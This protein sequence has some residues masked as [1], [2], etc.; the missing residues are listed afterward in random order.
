M[1]TEA[2]KSNDIFGHP[3]GLFVLFFTE[4]WERF[5]Y[6]GMRALLVLYMVQYLLVDPARSSQVIGYPTLLSILTSVFGELNIQQIS[7]QIYG[8]YT[9]FVYLTPLFGGILADRYLGQHKTV[10][11]G[12]IFFVIG[13]FL[14][15]IESMFIIAMIFLFIGNGC[16]KPNISTQVGNCYADDD[17]R[18]DRAYLIFY[19]GINLGAFF[20]P[21]V[22][23]TLGQ[24]LGWHYGF[25]AAGFGMIIGLLTYHFGSHLVPK[26][27]SKVYAALD[28][29]EKRKLTK[30]EWYSVWSIV[31][32]CMLALVFWA[33]YEQQGNTLQLWA[34]E[35]TAWPVILGFGIPST[36]FQSFN[37]IMI[38]AIVPL[39]NIFWGWQASKGKEPSS[40]TKMGIGCFLCGSAYL[41]MIAGAESIA[42]ST[43]RASVMWLVGTV[44]IFTLGEL[45]LSP[46]GLSL[47][48]KVSPKP[49][50]STMMGVWF[51]SSAL[52]NYGT[53][54]LGMYYSKMT[55]NAFFFM[56][57]AL[58][59]GTGVAFILARSLIAKGIGKAV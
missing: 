31:A 4:M 13:H 50:V 27:K 42:D 32:F 29:V 19:Q 40:I 39:M 37:P 48:T 57:F 34:D 15:A 46:I 30:A 33:I 36:W 18:R 53:G 6:Y 58:G 1:A 7:S 22:C 26:E 41:V 55:P 2:V 16:F 21:I 54:L 45:Y 20:S 25:A 11:I 28:Q 9:M 12:G 56:L 52:G 59:V 43:E 23:G 8:L 35:K 3:K 17:P 5:S 47:V 49:V 44:L 24:K 38:I 14:M 10:Y 51:A